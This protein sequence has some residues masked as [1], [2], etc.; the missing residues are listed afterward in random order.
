MDF[1]RVLVFSV[2]C[3]VRDGRTVDFT[4]F[5]KVFNWDVNEGPDGEAFFVKL[6]RII[7]FVRL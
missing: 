1:P 7:I 6:V 3:T 4:L 2:S 5:C